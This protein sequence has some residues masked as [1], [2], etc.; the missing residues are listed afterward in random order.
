M[1]VAGM[2][3]AALIAAMALTSCELLQRPLAHPLHVVYLVDCSASIKPKSLDDAFSAIRAEAGRLRR[4]DR[5]TVIPITGDAL[6]DVPGRILSR[7]VP[8]QRQPY[9]LDLKIFRKKFS[10]ELRKFELRA[11]THPYERTD[12]LGTVAVAVQ[13]FA[14]DD[15]QVRK[16][17]VIFSDFIEEDGRWN[18][19]NDPRFENKSSARALAAH[20]SKAEPRLNGTQVYLIELRS[21]EMK[22]LGYERREAITEFWDDYFAGCFLRTHC[23]VHPIL[24][25]TKY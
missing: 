17:L 7:R 22:R 2:V 3:L 5:I 21:K 11:Q 14:I 4:G 12:I 13:E 25:K 15:S 6:N 1:K 23:K 24:I 8:L 9:D 20:L 18:F 19:M 16:R 10:K